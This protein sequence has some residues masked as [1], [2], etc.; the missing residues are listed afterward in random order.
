MARRRGE[1]FDFVASIV[2]GLIASHS[3]DAER[4]VYATQRREQIRASGISIRWRELYRGSPAPSQI[5]IVRFVSAAQKFL[6][7]VELVGREGVGA[8][9]HDVGTE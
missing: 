9:Q 4:L 1:Q 6:A 2:H 8:D 5:E 7:G 3:V